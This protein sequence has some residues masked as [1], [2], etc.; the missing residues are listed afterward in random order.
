M[1]VFYDLFQVV[2]NPDVSKRTKSLFFSQF[3]LKQTAQILLGSG[4]GEEELEIDAASDQTRERNEGEEGEG[5]GEVETVTLKQF[6]Y[7]F[8]LEL[9]TD[10]SRGICYKMKD[11]PSGLERYV[12]SFWSEFSF[13]QCQ[14]MVPFFLEQRTHLSCGCWCLSWALL[15]MHSCGSLWSEWSLPVPTYSSRSCLK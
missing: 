2:L 11:P 3:V 5:E 14:L 15:G 1:I 9:C 8:L 12:L 4:R 10:F 13:S 7:D 6:T